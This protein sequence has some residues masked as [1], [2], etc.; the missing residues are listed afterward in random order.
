MEL[1]G[2]GRRTRRFPYAFS[3]VASSAVSETCREGDGNLD[4]VKMTLT[5]QH[6][7]HVIQT[8]TKKKPKQHISSGLIWPGKSKVFMWDVY[9]YPFIPRF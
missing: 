4:R 1:E 9:Q 2:M 6:E 8:K 7:T 5:S 3:S